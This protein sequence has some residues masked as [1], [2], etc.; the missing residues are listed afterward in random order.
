ML[1]PLLPAFVSDRE[2]NMPKQACHKVECVR[3]PLSSWGVNKDRKK[4][5]ECHHYR[6][7]EK[8]LVAVDIM[9]S[10][11]KSSSII[12]STTTVVTNNVVVVHIIIITNKK[13]Q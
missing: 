10:Q 12:V 2:E 4:L 3:P 1:Y 8:S 11:A 9:T 6:K 7:T 5:N 13:R